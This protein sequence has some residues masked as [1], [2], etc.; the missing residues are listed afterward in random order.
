MKKIVLIRHAKS[1][2]EF[3]ELKD[4]DRPL[5]KRGLDDAPLM[6]K[7]LKDLHITPDVIIS[8]PAARAMTTA[9]MIAQEIGF[10]QNQIIADP[11]LYLESKSKLLKE[12]NAIDDRYNIVF[13]VGHNPG[14]TDLANSLSGDSI[15]NIP[16]VVQSEFNLNVTS[17]RKLK[18]EWVKSYFLNFQKSTGRKLK[19]LK[20]R[21]FNRDLSWLSFNYRVL[22]EANNREV[23]L[24]ERLNFLAIYS[25][26]LDEFLP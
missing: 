14:L 17:G 10:D 12:I 22:Q 4:V 7:V 15:D 26:N 13:L 11:K 16:T 1:S 3:P 23:P 20:S 9:K 19:K 8:S 24:I 2:W 5:K 21:Y 25:S 6:G 18:K